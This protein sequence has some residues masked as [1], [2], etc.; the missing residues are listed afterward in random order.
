VSDHTPGKTELSLARAH[1]DHAVEHLDRAVRLR[2][3]ELVLEAYPLAVRLNAYGEYQEDGALHLHATQV[4]GDTSVVI[5]DGEV[6][7]WLPQWEETFDEIDTLLDELA[8]VD[9]TY[10]GEHGFVLD[11]EG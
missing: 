7:D 8:G 9:D 5:A 11:K 1:L 4:L 2:V 3:S 10:H 6:G